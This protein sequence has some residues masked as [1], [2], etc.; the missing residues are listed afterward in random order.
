MKKF[1]AVFS[2]LQ[3]GLEK[4]QTIIKVVK[5][6]EAAITAFNAEAQKQGLYEQ[7]PE[8]SASTTGNKEQ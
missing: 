6:I 3:R 1:L 7:L 4:V 5:C 8:Q 2:A